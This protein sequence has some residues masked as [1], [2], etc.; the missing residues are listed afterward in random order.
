MK[1]AGKSLRTEQLDAMMN[2]ADA[3][4]NG[5]VDMS[6]FKVVLQAVKAAN[7]ARAVQEAFRAKLRMQALQVPPPG[8]V[9]VPTTTLGGVAVEAAKKAKGATTIQATARGKA[10]RKLAKKKKAARA[11]VTD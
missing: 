1:A 10:A 4:A 5:D 11:K 9:Q 7:A 3:D 8:V 6:E 2:V